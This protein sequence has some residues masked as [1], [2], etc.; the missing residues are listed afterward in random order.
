MRLYN[1]IYLIVSYLSYQYKYYYCFFV[2]YQFSLRSI[3]CELI[4]RQ[5]KIF[6]F[7]SY[8]AYIL[9]SFF[10]YSENSI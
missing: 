7:F 9:H 10:I 6:L 5:S 8:I 1:I 3:K 2:V 4:H